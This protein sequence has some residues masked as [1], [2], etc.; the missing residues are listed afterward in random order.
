MVAVK[1]SKIDDRP[2]STGAPQSYIKLIMIQ[3][4]K[5]YVGDEV[6]AIIRDYRGSIQ[7]RGPYL[8]AKVLGGGKYI[9]CY[10]NGDIAESGNEIH[11]KNF[12]A[13]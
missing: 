6:Y 9:L 2:V 12:V 5:F 11:E 3:M 7:R 10:Y 1:S 13:A 8:I 4:S